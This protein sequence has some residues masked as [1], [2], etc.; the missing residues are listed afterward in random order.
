MITKVQ[1]RK[2]IMSTLSQN[3]TFVILSVF[4]LFGIFM[5]AISSENLDNTATD[6]ITK[7]FLSNIS[8]RESTSI[9][10]IFVSSL[11]SSF[12]FI[13]LAFFMG[14]SMW[15]CILAPIVPLLRGFCLGISQTYLYSTYGLKGIG[16]QL[17]VLLPGLFMS[18][19]AI[20]LMAREAIRLSHNFSSFMLFGKR[21]P[22]GKKDD[23]RTYF[24]RTGCVLGICVVASVIDIVFN[25]LFL[26]FFSF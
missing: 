10:Y 11:A 26:R 24:L 5:G 18:S 22:F 25:I 6:K 9:L 23:I 17:L 8:A 15:G 1:K 19:L 4:F 20:L 13:L 16:F 21:E 2:V 7:L 3:K 12:L 14:L